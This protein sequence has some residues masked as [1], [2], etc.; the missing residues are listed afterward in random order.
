MKK[1]L[2]AGHICLD[3]TPVF[4]QEAGDVSLDP[5]K[6]FVVGPAAISTGGAVANTGLAM[7]LFGADVTL[8]GKVGDD[9]FGELV[10]S[11]VQSCGVKE[12]IKSDDQCATSYTVVIAPPDVD[13]TFLHCPG[14][15]DAFS[16]QDITQEDLGGID[17]LHFGYPPLMKRMFQQDGEELLCIMK[18][19][20]ENGVIT[21]LDMAAVD[22][23]AEA[24]KADWKTILKK[25]LPFVDLF[26][27]SFEE[28]CFMLRRERYEELVRKGGD[29]CLLTNTAELESM[30]EEALALGASC[31]ML[32]AGTAGIWYACKRYSRFVRQ[33]GLPVDQWEGKKGF[34]PSFEP[35][36][37]R[38]ATGAGDVAIAAFLTAMLRGDG[39]KSCVT[40]ASA[41]G[42]ACVED[43]S[44]LGGLVSLEELEK[45][46][47]SG[48]KKQ[49]LIA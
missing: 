34:I 15:N 41:A 25:V 16:E 1:V 42:A 30:A 2:V 35:V 21:S 40:L 46:I 23:A 48:W 3:I 31:V 7:H 19:A 45:R 43:Y 4:S 6:L 10:R 12:N 32:K 33:L 8:L 20:H 13:R 9:R 38:S 47:E 24:G 5:G 27:P 18:K 26:V 22:P 44:A 37:V 29:L 17:L 49:I 14:A 11:A 28:L 36:A 39:L